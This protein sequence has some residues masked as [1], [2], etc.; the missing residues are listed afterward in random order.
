VD[1]KGFKWCDPKR[2]GVCHR[3]GKPGHQAHM[4]VGDMPRYIKEWVLKRPHSAHVVDTE[5]SANAAFGPYSSSPPDHYGH[6]LI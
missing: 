3:C 4:C 5:A 6:I 2:D 1:D